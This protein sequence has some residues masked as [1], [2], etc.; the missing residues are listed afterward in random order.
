MGA[1]G[2]KLFTTTIRNMG[3]TPPRDRGAF[4]VRDEARRLVYVWKEAF[5]IQLSLCLERGGVLVGK[6][7]LDW[8]WTL[9]L[10]VA[11]CVV[12]GGGVAE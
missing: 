1:F 10:F 4:F 5:Q 12:R 7:E 2:S 11:A 6:A 8:F 3:S 9:F